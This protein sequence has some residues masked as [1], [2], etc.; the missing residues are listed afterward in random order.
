MGVAVNLERML[1]AREQRAARQSAALARFDK[2]LL[3][4]TVVMPGPVKDGW[5]PRRVLAGAV[6]EVEAVSSARRWGVLSREVLW[7]ETGP[8]ALYVMDADARIL[9]LV[10]VELED[11]HPLGRLWDLDV[12]APRLNRLSR[13]D[14]GHPARRCLLCGR[15]AHA[16]SRSRQHPLEE[17][18][19][20]IGRIVHEHDLGSAA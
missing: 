18:L 8:E 7:R 15:P 6:Q 1:A 17:L 16:C 3:S 12:I 11:R 19:S 10:T 5:L 4:M 14:L 13:R 2:P 20:T 9:K